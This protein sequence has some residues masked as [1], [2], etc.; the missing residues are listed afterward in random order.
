MLA[1]GDLI[2]ASDIV[3]DDTMSQAMPTE[4]APASEPIEPRPWQFPG[5]TEE[6]WPSF[7]QCEREIIVA[8]LRH[9]NYNQAAAAR[10]LKLDRSVLRRRVKKLGIDI[11]QSTPGRP[12]SCS[13]NDQ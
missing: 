1:R 5:E 4:Q 13:Q 7:E 9:T 3:F 12:V 10:L 6:Q 11:S 8:T 2:E